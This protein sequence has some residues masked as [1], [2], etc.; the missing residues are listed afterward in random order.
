M[1]RKHRRTHRLLWPML[2]LCL[3]AV[4]GFALV[5]RPEEPVNPVWP[6]VLVPVSR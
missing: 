3:A 2:A 5:Q 1:K 4:V 6:A